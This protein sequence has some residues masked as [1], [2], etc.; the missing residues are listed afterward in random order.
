MNK[1]NKRG[2]RRGMTRTLE[3]SC[4]SKNGNWKGGIHYRSDGYILI[5]IGVF[6]RSY[7]GKR[8]DLLHRLIMEKHLGRKLL[9]SEIVH[10]KNGDRT[11]N[12]VKNLKIML[13]SEHAGSHYKADNKTGRFIKKI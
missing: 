11:D 9:D 7:K 5:R 6:P 13:Q 1:T 8:Y 2:D 4:Q 12:R 3:D 10:H